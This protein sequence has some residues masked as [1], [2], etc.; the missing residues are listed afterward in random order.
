MDE[1]VCPQC[2]FHDRHSISFREAGDP[3][4]TIIGFWPIEEINHVGHD[5]RWVARCHYRT[6]CCHAHWDLQI[7]EE[8]GQAVIP[9]GIPVVGLDEPYVI[10]PQSGDHPASAQPSTRIQEMENFVHPASATYILGN[11]HYQ[12]PS[13]YFDCDLLVGITMDDLEAASY[14]PFY[15]NQMAAMIW[16]DRK[17]K[18]SNYQ[19][20]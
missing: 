9:K 15:G 7:I 11:T 2:G 8:P 13:D 4:V 18:G 5:D 17:L 6:V 16:Y 10:D 19:I 1:P 20:S 14:S 3:L 12:R